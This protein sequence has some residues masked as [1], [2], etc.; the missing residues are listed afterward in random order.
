MVWSADAK[1]QSGAEPAGQRTWTRRRLLV[2]GG[3]GVAGVAAAG[4]LGYPWSRSGDPGA[5]HG[6]SLTSGATTGTGQPATAGGQTFV[7]RSDLNPPALTVA[8]LGSPPGLP[9]YIFL[10]NK[11]Y[12]L[13]AVGQA[14][15]LIARRDGD[16][17]WFSPVTRTVMNFDVQVYKGKQ[18][19]TWWHGE[20]GG[21]YGQGDCYIADSS[22]SVIATVKAGK[23]L[24][25]DMHEFTITQQGTALI[26]CYQQRNNVDLSAVGG[27]VNGAALSGVV[28][29]ID[30]ATGDV[31]FEWSSLD[32]VPVTESYATLSGTGTAA[33]PYDYFHI[34]S[35]GVA[36]DG[37]LLVSSRNTWTVYKIGRR[38]GKVKWRLGGKK[39]NFTVGPGVTFHWQHHVRWHGTDL[40]TVFDNGSSPAVE[41]QSRALLLQLD[42]AKMHATLVRA[43]TNPARLLADNQGSIQLLPGNRAFVGWGAEPYFS[44]FDSDGSLLLNGQFPMGDQSYRAFTSNWVGHPKDRP[45]VAVLSNQARGAAVYVSWNGATEVATWQVLAG[46]GESSL[47]V[48][49]TQPRSGFETVIAANSTGPYF[50]VTA[51]DRTGK[52]IGQSAIVKK[53]GLTAG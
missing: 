41:P 10:G 21:A 42:T 53:T 7:S 11:G 23:G 8:V 19:L 50:A 30:I 18:V 32:H 33:V 25:A 22:Y 2:G 5:T 6:A 3:G 27:K 49:A 37:D 12:K 20:T 17:A 26:D 4:A 44:E 48:V 28:Q 38:D 39:S 47:S 34:N 13:A 24:M 15:L 40:L 1:S 52:L 45:A 31:L 29:E 43:Y 9:G 16:I 51:H 14:G 46:K 36:P 35:I